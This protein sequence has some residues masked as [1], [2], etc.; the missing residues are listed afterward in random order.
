MPSIVFE[1]N[2]I[3]REK[4]GEAPD[5]GELIDLCD[6]LLAP[7]P[8]SCRSASCGTCQVEILE[9][10]ELMEPPNDAERELL[11]LLAGPPQNRLACQARVKQG[12]GLVRL[13]PVGT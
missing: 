9:G 11:E 6:E 8:F 4:R 1:G 10:S 2:A 12:P 5:G 3:G 13:R 7:V